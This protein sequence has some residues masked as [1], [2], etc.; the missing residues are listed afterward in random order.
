M[1]KK[2]RVTGLCL[3]GVLAAGAAFGK[4]SLPEGWQAPDG[5]YQAVYDADDGFLPEGNSGGNKPKFI[6]TGYGTT[7][8]LAAP[9]AEM[10]KD[11]ETGE[12]VLCLVNSPTAGPLYRLL[13]G[14]GQGSTNDLITLD[15]RLRFPEKVTSNFQLLVSIWRPTSAAQKETGITEVQYILRFS[16][17][18]FTRLK[19][20]WHDLRFHIDVAKGTVKLY[21]DGGRRP[22]STTGVTLKEGH[23]ARNQM[24]FGD[25]GG[26]GGI[27][28]VNIAYIAWT[29]AELAPTA[30]AE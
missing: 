8:P 29:N 13:R 17:A 6:N 30:Q 1:G 9:S 21:M 2:K 16:N 26:A 12:Q 11:E 27:G 15:M 24:E 10:T 5:G 18:N 28:S 22:V 23:N 3:A 25:G 20:G 7:P 4:I 19:E 14:A